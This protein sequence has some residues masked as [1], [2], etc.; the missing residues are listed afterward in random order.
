MKRFGRGQQPWLLGHASGFAQP[1]YR[2]REEKPPLPHACAPEKVCAK[3][4]LHQ[5]NRSWLSYTP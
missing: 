3:P 4:A 1:L 5:A 2:H